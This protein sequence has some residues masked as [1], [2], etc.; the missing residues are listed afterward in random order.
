MFLGS[1]PRKTVLYQ[2]E[3]HKCLSNTNSIVH[4]ELNVLDLV[5][6]DHEEYMHLPRVYRKKKCFGM[7]WLIDVLKKGLFL[8]L[9]ASYGS[10][11]INKQGLW[12]IEISIKFWNSQKL[13]RGF[14]SYAWSPRVLPE[15][16]GRGLR[17]TSENLYPIYDQNLQYLLP[18][19]CHDQT[20]ETL[21]KGLGH[22]I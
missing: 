11:L 8:T 3:K 7:Y 17:P 13:F 16:L 18:L 12:N 4:Q 10:C 9:V 5:R 1:T 22:A 19:L 2:P 6:K 15:K 21:L 20:F 14:G